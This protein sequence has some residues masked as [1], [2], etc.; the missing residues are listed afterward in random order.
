MQPEGQRILHLDL[1]LVCNNMGKTWSCWVQLLVVSCKLV[2]LACA[3]PKNFGEVW[4]EF[5]S[6]SWQ[7]DLVP[8]EKSQRSLCSTV[9]SQ[10][11]WFWFGHLF[12]FV[13]RLGWLGWMLER[14]CNNTVDGRNHAP[15][16]NFWITMNNRMFS[17]LTGA[18]FLPLTVWQWFDYEVFILPLSG[19]RGGSSN[20]FPN[21]L[22]RGLGK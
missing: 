16:V 11:V 20:F 3:K 10:A 17:T 13:G 19:V 15:A 5:L 2:Q 4:G 22:K 18:G 1:C 21:A 14:F 9:D 6:S 12:F 8:K 7:K